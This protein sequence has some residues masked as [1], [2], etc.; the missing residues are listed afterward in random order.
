MRQ[1][2]YNAGRIMREE[3]TIIILLFVFSGNDKNTE[4]IIFAIG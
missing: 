2:Q 3:R 1:Q 4:E